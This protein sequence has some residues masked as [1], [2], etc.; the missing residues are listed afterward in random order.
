MSITN[1][2]TTLANLKRR[3]QEAH[4]YTATTISFTLAGSVIADS[5]KGLARFLTGK[6]ILISGTDS[7]NGYFNIA[8]GGVA[9]QIITTEALVNEIAGDTVVITDVTDPVDDNQLE[10]IIEA[11]SRKIDE[12]CGRFF[13][14]TASQDRYYTPEFSN[15]LT[16]L[17]IV[18]ITAIVADE[19][20]DRV[21][22]RTW[23][24]TDYDLTPFNAA[25]DGKPYTSIELT[26]RGNY[27]FPRIS[28]GVK[29]T[30]TFGYPS[31]PKQ[32]QEACLL[33]S[34]RLWK[35]KDAIFGIIGS[36][37]MG[38]QMVIAKLDPDVERLLMPFRKMDI[39]GV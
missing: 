16:G 32:I 9:A 36:A 31:V 33:Q 12:E 37:E 3:L 22:E 28:K 27:T 39:L 2:Y 30:G 14:V 4:T 25:T 24:S 21:Y 17:D 38:Q 8:T 26:P 23:A 19:D 1:G 13:Y 35:R 34:M 10:S 7:N 18:T 20:G 5:A 11:V 29:L 15:E 6:R